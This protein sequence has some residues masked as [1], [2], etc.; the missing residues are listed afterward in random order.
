MNPE[1]HAHPDLTCPRERRPTQLVCFDVLS[2]ES[3]QT[4]RAQAGIRCCFVS[5]F[6]DGS[7]VCIPDVVV[8]AETSSLERLIKW[9]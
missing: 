6:G 5:R 7:P 9:K 8:F 2:D 4:E 3:G 1:I